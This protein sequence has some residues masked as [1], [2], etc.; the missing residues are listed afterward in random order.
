MA[1]VLRRYGFLADTYHESPCLLTLPSR[2]RRSKLCR[3]MDAATNDKTIA[4]FDWDRVDEIYRPLR[5]SYPAGELV[6]KTGSGWGPL[7]AFLGVPE[8]DEPYP[9]TNSTKEFQEQ[10]ADEP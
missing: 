6:Y 1:N 4:A 10:T 5:I 7:C 8:P 2:V 3:S 9:L